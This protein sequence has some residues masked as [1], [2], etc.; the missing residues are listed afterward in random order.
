MSTKK[1]M[2]IIELDCEEDMSTQKS[3]NA[4]RNSKKIMSTCINFKCISGID[5]KKAP[6]F[7]CAY[8]G[9]NS[10]KKKKTIYMSKMF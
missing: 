7:A 8:Y 6:S 5:M 2:E 1:P 9:V 3:K 4:D 10:V